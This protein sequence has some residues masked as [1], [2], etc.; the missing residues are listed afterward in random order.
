[1]INLPK[2]S[3]VKIFLYGPDLEEENLVFNNLSPA[4]Q[5]NYLF[6]IPGISGAYYMDVIIDGK[7]KRFKLF[8]DVNL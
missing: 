5:N 1:M 3:E 4:G 6:H 7:A 8:K 2:E